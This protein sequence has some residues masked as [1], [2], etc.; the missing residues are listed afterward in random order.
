MFKYIRNFSHMFIL[1]VLKFGSDNSNMCHLGVG[2]G[3]A[4]GICID[5]SYPS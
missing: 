2:V 1:A 3:I 5:N 4:F